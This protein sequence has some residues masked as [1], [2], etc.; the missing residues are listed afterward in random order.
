LQETRKVI[1]QGWNAVADKLEA[2]GEIVLGGDV[3]YFAMN[4]PPA[5]T[6]RERLAE[7]FVRFAKAQRSARTRGDD[8]VRDRTIERTR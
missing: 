7:Q 5:L 3:R 6:D 4:L 1:I 8:R 2:Q